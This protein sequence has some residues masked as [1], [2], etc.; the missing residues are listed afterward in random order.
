MTFI[1][2]DKDTQVNYRSFDTSISY[3]YM[4]DGKLLIKVQIFDH[5]DVGLSK[6][7]GFVEVRRKW[8]PNS[9]VRTDYSVNQQPK[10]DDPLYEYVKTAWE[11]LDEAKELAKS[12]GKLGK[13]LDNK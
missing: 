10:K 3:V 1:K 4:R 13:L 12:E 6:N 5:S 11:C 9:K 2:L 7:I 8:R